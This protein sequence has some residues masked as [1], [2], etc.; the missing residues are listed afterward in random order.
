MFLQ[1]DMIAPISA[2]TNVSYVEITLKPTPAHTARHDQVTVGGRHAVYSF[3]TRWNHTGKPFC[4]GIIN[5][6]F[7]CN[8]VIL[9]ICFEFYFTLLSGACF[10]LNHYRGV[11]PHHPLEEIIA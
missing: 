9:F 6:S 2:L 1:K 5:M 11:P 4:D 3:M 10:M 8:I 7:E